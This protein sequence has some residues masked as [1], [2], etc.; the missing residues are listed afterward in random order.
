MDSIKQHSDRDC[1]QKACWQQ[2]TV[3]LVIIL[4]VFTASCASKQSIRATEIEPYTGPVNTEVLKKHIGF[5]NISSIKSLVDVGIL[6][7]GEPVGSFSGALAYRSPGDLRISIFGPF[8][9]IMADVLMS[10]DIFQIYFAPKNILYEWESPDISLNSLADDRFVYRMGEENNEYVLFAARE[11]DSDSEVSARYVFDK[12]Y[13]LNRYIIFY[14]DGEEFVRIDFNDFKGSVPERTRISLSNRS[15][16]EI[17]LSDPDFSADI[18]AEYY[19]PV[20]HG[21]RK[22]LPLQDIFKKLLR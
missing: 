8:G 16:L 12:T 11:K 6:K 10:R 14:K 17:S 9:I 1:P 21:D 15:A 4:L 22:V 20:E 13:I 5:G 3:L 7:K 2:V 19:K 18:P